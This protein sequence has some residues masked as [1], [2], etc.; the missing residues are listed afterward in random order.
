MRLISQE[1]LARTTARRKKERN[2]FLLLTVLY[3][4]AALTLF[5]LSSHEY[6][7]YMVGDVALSIV[8]G[9]YAVYFFTVRYFDVRSLEK[10]TEKALSAMSEKEYGV[11]LREEGPVT[12]EGVTFLSC[13][14]EV[15]G[16][17][18]EICL[19]VR[20]VPFAAG[21]RYVLT[22]AAGVLVEWEAAHE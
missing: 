1:D 22:I 5:L 9:F 13:I 3:V 12:K 10:Y 7:W 2:I 4:A 11:F 20:E 17:E 16:D 19:L 14:F 21:E 15:L 6:T 18:R 8:Y